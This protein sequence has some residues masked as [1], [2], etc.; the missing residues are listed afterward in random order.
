MR[1]R[2]LILLCILIISFSIGILYIHNYSPIW[3]EDFWF[4]WQFR[5][6]FN[7]HWEPFV[8]QNQ[9]PKTLSLPDTSRSLCFVTLET[10]GDK[11]E[12]VKLHNVNIKN[13]VEYQNNKPHKNNYAYT[14]LTE[15][16]SKVAHPHNVYWCKFFCLRDIL[17][18]GQYDY[19][20]WLD[21]DTIINDFELDFVRLLSNYKSDWFAGVDDAKRFDHLNAG[22]VVVR[23]S[24]KGKEMLSLIT[25]MYTDKAFQSK[26]IRKQDDSYALSGN[27]AGV[28]YEQGVMNQILFFRFREHVTV[29]SP[30]II[31][32]GMSCEGEFIIH[33]S[34]SSSKDRATCF[35]KYTPR[36]TEK[37]ETV[38]EN[39][40]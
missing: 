25:D 22:V 2:F 15:C 1:K 26:C 12:Y 3:W 23:N 4:N 38:A 40:N 18:Q 24:D 14:F 19:V 31:H 36:E 13:Y 33:M 6:R 5:S 8:D 27:W 21:S 17:E 11:D 7:K 39:K 35:R 10:R 37:D 16:Q 9:I 20:V 34:A 29:L 32:N 28:C 30:K